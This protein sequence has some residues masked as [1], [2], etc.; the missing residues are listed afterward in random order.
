M[1]AARGRR[2]LGEGLILFL[3]SLFTTALTSQGFFHTLLLTR[4][5]IEGMTFYFLDDVFRLNLALE[6]PEGILD[7][8]ALLHSNFGQR[9][10][11]PNSSCWTLVASQYSMGKS[12]AFA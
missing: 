10:T 7:R 2:P 9:L 11:P 3:A 5:Q 4:L 12:R 1:A 8:F 6:T